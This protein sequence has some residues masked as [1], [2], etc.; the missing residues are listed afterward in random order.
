MRKGSTEAKASEGELGSFEGKYPEDLFNRTFVIANQSIGH[1]A[2]DTENTVIIFGESDDARYDVPKS[3]IIPLGGSITIR[4]ASSLESYRQDRDS[5]LPEEK[6]RPSAEQI[7][8]ASIAHEREE[9]TRETR[10]EPVLRERQELA[11]A[12]REATTAVST[13]EGYIEQAEPEIVRQLK[14]AAKE[15]SELFYAGSKLAKKKAKEKKRQIDEKR[16]LM[17]AEKIASMGNLAAQFTEDYDRI[18]A[19]IRTRPYLEQSRMY[20]G[21]ITL[22]DYQRKLAVARRDMS[23]R[24]ATSVRGSVVP[25]REDQASGSR[26]KAKRKIQT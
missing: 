18:V 7:R 3:E 25:S 15:F 8:Q 14:N 10:A 4:D 11:I 24:V 23:A 20:D 9:I 22:M 12:P 2:K 17:D 5:P 6:L 13:S 26:R 21:L 1:V 16:A 19:E